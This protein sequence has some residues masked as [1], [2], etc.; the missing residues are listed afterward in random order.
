MKISVKLNHLNMAASEI[1]LVGAGIPKLS[2]F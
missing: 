2:N 1:L